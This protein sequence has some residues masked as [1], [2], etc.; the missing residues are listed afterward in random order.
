MSSLLIWYKQVI[1]LLLV[2]PVDEQGDLLN[3]KSPS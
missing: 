2:E 3:I 1:D